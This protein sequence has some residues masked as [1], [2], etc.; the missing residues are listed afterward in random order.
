MEYYVKFENND[1]NEHTNVYSN[2]NNNK[3]DNNNNKND[4]NDNENTNIL[5]S[6]CNKY[7]CE[8]INNDIIKVKYNNS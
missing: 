2:V 6:S 7:K 3:N 5:Y 1:D 8:L 4:N